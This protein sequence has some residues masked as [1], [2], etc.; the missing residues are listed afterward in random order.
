[1]GLPKNG[2]FDFAEGLACRVGAKAN[3]PLCAGCQRNFHFAFLSSTSFKIFVCRPKK[4][5]HFGLA[6][7]V[8]IEFIYLVC[9][10][11]FNRT[12]SSCRVENNK[13]IA[14]KLPKQ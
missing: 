3:V 8:G 6:V 2:S 10:V 9:H 5:K 7:C 14:F 11:L 1:M 4:I 13:R 12:L